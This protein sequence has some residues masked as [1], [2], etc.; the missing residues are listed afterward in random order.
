MIKGRM[1]NVILGDGSSGCLNVWMGKWMNSLL[2]G[3]KINVCIF[4]TIHVIFPVIKQLRR[5]YRVFFPDN[6]VR[7][8]STQLSES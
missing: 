6:P 1:D 7:E 3:G 4:V 8:P 2:H 5:I